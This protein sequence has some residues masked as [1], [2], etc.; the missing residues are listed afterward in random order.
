M[1]RAVAVVFGTML[2]ATMMI[3]AKL[4]TRPPNVLLGGSDDAGA[5]SAADPGSTA[6]PLPPGATQVAPGPGA[7]PAPGTTPSLHPATSSP[8]PPPT[9]A[10]LKD[11][12]FPGT[13]VTE[14]Y[15][16]VKVTIV[17]SG[18]RITDVTATY[19][20]GEDSGDINARAIP[21]LRQEA[22]TAQSASIAT[23][24]GATYTSNAYRTS[25]QAAI[26]TAKA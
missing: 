25:L 20:T 21:R 18:G 3:T 5:T 9:T 14:R 23:V 22:L 8:S 24:S 16:T 12:T 19:P 10:G 7:T 4:G 13:A 1:R 2:G 26:D 17:V 11:G 15:G 6:S